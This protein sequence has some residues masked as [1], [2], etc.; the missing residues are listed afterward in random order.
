MK[1]LKWLISGLL[2]G[3]KLTMSSDGKSVY[4]REKA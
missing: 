3:Y 4:L 2:R 1:I